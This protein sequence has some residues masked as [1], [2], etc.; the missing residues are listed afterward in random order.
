MNTYTDGTLTWTFDDLT[1]NDEWSHLTKEQIR[2]ID[3]LEIGQSVEVD[4]GDDG[5]ITLT[6]VA[7]VA[8][9][10][11]D[12]RPVGTREEQLAAFDVAATAHGVKL[13]HEAGELPS[14]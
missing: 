3:A 7:A 1:G 6:R 13:R 9:L 11:R 14:Y 8:P 2:R 4:G 12:G 5:T 10:G